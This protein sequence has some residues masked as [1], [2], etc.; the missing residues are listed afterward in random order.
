MTRRLG[1]AVGDHDQ[2]ADPGPA[3]VLETLPIRTRR[4]DG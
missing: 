4:L 2:A 1:E 3:A